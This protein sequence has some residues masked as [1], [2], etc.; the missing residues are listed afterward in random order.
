MK[1]LLIHEEAELEFNHAIDYYQ[2]RSRSGTGILPVGPAG[3]LPA[4]ASGLVKRDTCPPHRQDACA[5]IDARASRSHPR[6]SQ[7]KAL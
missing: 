6:R 7:T 5:T 1:Q 3:V 2:V 4:D